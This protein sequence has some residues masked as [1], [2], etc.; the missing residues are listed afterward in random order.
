[1]KHELFGVL[2]MG[3]GD[4]VWVAVLVRLVA[5]REG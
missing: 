1:M 4:R 2:M 3:E 5:R